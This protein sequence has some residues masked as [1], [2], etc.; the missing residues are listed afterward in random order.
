MLM[1]AIPP[2]S[3]NSERD[4]GESPQRRSVPITARL[5]DFLYH[6]RGSA[7]DILLLFLLVEL[8]CV[9]AGLVVPDRFPYLD[10]ANI[11]VSLQAIPELGIMALGVGLL[12]VAGEFDLS[13]GASYTFTAVVMATVYQETGISDFLAAALALIIGVAIALV[14][15]FITIRFN[16]PSFIVTLGAGLFWD[17]MVLFYHGAD[18]VAF[19][20][21]QVFASIT[22][23]SIGVI[24]APFIWFV[25]LAIV[26]WIVLHHH[27]LGNHLYAV[28]GNKATALAIGISPGRVKALAFAAAGFC[29]AMSGILATARVTAIQ[30]GQGDALPLQAIAACVIGGVVLTGGR[31][32]VLGICLG[33]VLM[34]TIQDILLLVGAPAFYLNIF[35]GG[36][37]VLAA[38]F[39]ELVRQQGGG[40]S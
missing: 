13:V 23:G 27:K 21:D 16:I 1:K 15:A 17:G 31:G 40:R 22:T 3:S 34:Y 37:I 35:V 18:T 6:R 36:L 25:G 14:N 39:N 29:A 19:S 38:M 12:M 7:I 33:A 28:G 11:S 32:T 9:I 2:L 30:P 20:P 4:R 10:S 24:Q 26:A 5:A 8:A